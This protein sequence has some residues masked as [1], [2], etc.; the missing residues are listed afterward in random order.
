MTN[1]V[2][3]KKRTLNVNTAS[4]V[5]DSNNPVTLKNFPALGAT[6]RI[7]KLIDVDASLEANGAT[8]VYDSSNDR[9]IVKKLDLSDVTGVLDGGEF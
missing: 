3:V 1:V 8:L 4:S 9:Y 5:I 7:D 6:N 2:V